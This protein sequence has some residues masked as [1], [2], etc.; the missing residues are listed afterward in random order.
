MP[1]TG[2]YLWATGFLCWRTDTSCDGTTVGLIMAYQFERKKMK[3][4]RE[5]INK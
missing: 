3:K 4:I 5:A 2:L 1:I